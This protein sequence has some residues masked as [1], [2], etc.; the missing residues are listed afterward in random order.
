MKIILSN[1]NKIPI[2]EQLEIQIRDQILDGSL[3]SGL[4]LPSIRK[5]ARDLGISVITIK[6]A[7][8]DLESEGY[9]HTMAGKGSFITSQSIEQLRDKKMVLS[10][11]ELERVIK[12]MK[13]LGL[14]RERLDETISLLWKDDEE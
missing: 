1:I 9:I 6:R 2:Y 5:L 13:Q 4:M 12:D 10:E 3:E 11:L 7:Y 14:S 8:D